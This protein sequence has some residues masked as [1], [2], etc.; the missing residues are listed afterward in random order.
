MSKSHP[1]LWLLWCLVA[2]TNVRADVVAYRGR[3]T[4]NGAPYHGA[5]QFRFAIIGSEGSVTW[6]TGDVDLLV[7]EGVYSVRLGDPASGMPSLSSQSLRGKCSLRI[8]VRHRAGTWAQVASDVPLQAAAAAPAETL[9]AAQATAMFTELQELRSRLDAMQKPAATTSAPKYVT[10]PIGNSPAFGQADAPLTLVEFTEFANGPSSIY[11]ADI[12]PG[13]FSGYVE[14]GKVRIVCRQVPQHPASEP[15]ARAAVCA[16]EQGK[17]REVRANLFALGP[18]L[19]T[20]TITAAARDAGLDMA[21][22][23]TAFSGRDA[24]ELV[25]ADLRDARAL[26]ISQTPTFVLGRAEGGRV[27]GVLLSGIV[28]VETWE[29]EI[30]KLLTAPATAPK[31]P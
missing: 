22:Y 20:E 30:Y 11:A 23:E 7:R 16:H 10:V 2:L 21:Q 19:T 26:G 1:L 13:L 3:L 25:Q 18:N 8:W 27:T 6:S 28:T 5:G 31:Q 29:A 12:F 17:F 15:A 4:M 9:T 24:A 14:T